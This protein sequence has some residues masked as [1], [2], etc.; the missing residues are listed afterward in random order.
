MFTLLSTDWCS[1]FG[2]NFNIDSIN[3]L[4]TVY[5][6]VVVVVVVVAYDF[7]INMQQLFSIITTASTAVASVHVA[8]AR[9]LSTTTTVTTTVTNYISDPNSNDKHASPQAAAA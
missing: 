3:C 7:N 1:D 4:T 6:V 5:V 8:P 9:L 2:Q